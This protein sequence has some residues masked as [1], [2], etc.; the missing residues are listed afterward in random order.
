MDK[1]RIGNLGLTFF[2]FVLLGLM[3]A[4]CASTPKIDWNS[5]VGNYTYDQAVLELG[6]PDKASTLSDGTTVAEWMTRRPD[7]SGLSFGFG[8]GI[9]TGGS[10]IGLGHS[11]GSGAPGEYLRLTFDPQG[12]LISW[13]HH[14]R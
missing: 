5:R 8:T 11:I 7:S 1:L 14:Y 6:P 13:S 12:Q 2:A 3:L 10:S 4:G 9:Y